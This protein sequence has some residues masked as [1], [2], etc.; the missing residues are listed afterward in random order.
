MKL[1]Q[2]KK[3]V[4]FLIS[5]ILI[6]FIIKYLKL[7]GFIKKIL[8]I[9]IPLFIGFI[10]AWLFNPLIDKLSKK[11][12]R[13]INSIILFL[14]IIITIILS[15]YYI[16]PIIYQE[17]SEVI[18]VL[19]NLFSSIEN[20]ITNM[21]L[22]DF[23]ENI[24]H[25]LVEN[26]PIYLLNLVKAI[27]K[28][29]GIIAL[30]LILGLYLSMDYKNIITF[31]HNIIPKK[32]KCIFI[33]LTNEVSEEVRKCIKG[34][35]LVALFVFIMDSILFYFI[36]LEAP[37]IFGFIC[38]ITDLIPYIGPYI[39]GIISILVGFT[40]SKITGLLTILVCLIV[41]AIENYILQPIIMSKSIKISPVL[42][43][44]GLL[45]FGNL[46]GIIGMIIS[47]PCVAILK[48]ILSHING[49]IERCKKEKI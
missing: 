29:F 18:K 22:N 16:T 10:Y 43:I 21:G 4:L 33:N 45:V 11:I 5:I 42:I 24:L 28:Y 49:V 30:G 38:G 12:P 27:I 31:I 23:L 39:G 40:K 20:R 8:I 9:L 35:L 17:I 36:K 19:P 46:F 44:I 41:Q 6:I 26:I 7:I 34:T 14:I 15:I 37:L 48:V 25:F 2:L 13:N 32:Y 3:V 47:T 1:E